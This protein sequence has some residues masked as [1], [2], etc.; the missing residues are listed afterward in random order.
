METWKDSIVGDWTLLWELVPKTGY[1]VL[2][3]TPPTEI[4]PSLSHQPGG[5]H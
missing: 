3:E 2:L 4:S 1:D 5:I